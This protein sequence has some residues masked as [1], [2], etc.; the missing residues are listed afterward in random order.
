MKRITDRI[1]DLLAEKE[2]VI[3]AIDGPCASGKSTL[4]KALSQIYDCNLIHMD[5]FFLRPQ[6]RTAQRLAQ[7]GGNLD[8]ERFWDEV[9]TPLIRFEEFSYRPYVCSLG[10][11]GNPIFVPRKKLYIIEGSY[12]Q[13]PFFGRSAYQLRVFLEID[14]EKQKERLAA[15]DPQKLER[16]IAEWIPKEASYFETFHIK[17]RADLCVEL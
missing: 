6:Q 15:R 11:L 17:D 5:D 12:S 7:I 2:R 9:M 14:P 13:H 4:A 16:F 3:V 10:E 1:D 8:R